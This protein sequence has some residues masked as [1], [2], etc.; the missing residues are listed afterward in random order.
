MYCVSQFFSFI[1]M[2]RDFLFLH[3]TIFHR[4]LTRVKV[5]SIRF[6]KDRNLGGM[7]GVSLR[8]KLVLL[9]VSFELKKNTRRF[10]S[11]ESGLNY[12]VNGIPDWN[13]LLSCMRLQMISRSVHV[14]TSRGYRKRLRDRAFLTLCL[15]SLWCPTLRR[16]LRRLNIGRNSH[17]LE[18][19][20]RKVPSERRALRLCGSKRPLINDFYFLSLRREAAI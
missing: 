2:S 8:S 15:C 7:V 17:L 19:R 14:T 5:L 3:L 9:N 16:P 10:Q 11:K 13:V 6:I 4:T 1:C 18:V 12:T 20:E